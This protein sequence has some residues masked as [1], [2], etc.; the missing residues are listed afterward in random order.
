MSLLPPDAPTSVTPEPVVPKRKRLSIPIGPKIALGVVFLFILAAL[1]ATQLAPSDPTNLA[2]FDLMNAELPP[3]FM[4]GGDSA[5][6]LG[7]DNQGRDLLSTILYGLRVSIAI[8]ASAVLL[9]MTTGVLLGVLAGYLG[10]WVDV[11]IMRIA[12]VILSLPTILMALLVSGI[13]R[14]IWPQ[15]AGPQWAPFILVGAIA[16]NEWVV[17]ARVARAALLVEV[18]KD[19]VR[20]AQVI[21]FPAVRIMWRHVLPNIL[22]PI[23]VIATVNLA[24][25]ILTEASL[26]F[27]GVGMPPTYP[28]LGTLVRIGNEYV[29]SGIWW[30]V[31]LPALTLVILILSVNI[32]GDWL[33]D[34]LNPK[35]G[36]RH[37]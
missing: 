6:W 13:A 22:S 33:R 31:V 2:S 7:T 32:V 20:A 37:E 17:Y 9:A 24:A 25:A 18:R 1:F 10:G 35:L 4:P 26:S 23:M 8:G 3:A 30:I 5:Y 21:G 14:A 27:L 19:Y 29:L 34:R 11:V 16:L 12:D 28:S 15:A 36:Q